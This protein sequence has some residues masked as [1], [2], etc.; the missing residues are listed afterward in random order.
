LQNAKL[1]YVFP[2]FPR[3]EWAE[4]LG[5]V[6]SDPTRLPTFL[7]RFCPPAAA[8][9]LRGRS[10]FSPD[11]S[12]PAIALLLVARRPVAG[13]GVGLC[14]APPRSRHDY[15]VL[16]PSPL[17]VVRSGPNTPP[18]ADSW[19]VPFSWGTTTSPPV[20]GHLRRPLASYPWWYFTPP[21]FRRRTSFRGRP[22]SASF[23]IWP[24]RVPAGGV[25][26]LHSLPVR[27]LVC[28][29]VMGGTS[30]DRGVSSA[31]DYLLP[32]VPRSRDRVRCAADGRGFPP[33]Q[34]AKRPVPKWTFRARRGVS[35]AG[36]PGWGDDPTRST[37][38][39]RH[40]R[41]SGV[42]AELIAR[43]APPAAAVLRFPGGSR[44]ASP[45]H[46][47]AGKREKG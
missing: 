4:G 24:A 26:E 2:R 21:R 45:S 35:T 5:P 16:G 8:V 22:P 27:V 13:R 9:M 39:A 33:E 6:R 47:G 28:F 34:P 32:G 31:P 37:G 7:Q 44:I 10:D 11:L 19:R 17:P 23:T 40:M 42:S 20:A 12:P 38:A 43:H 3:R 41:R 30:L 36:R 25:E 15:P 1:L 18:T 29:V 14:T 46:L